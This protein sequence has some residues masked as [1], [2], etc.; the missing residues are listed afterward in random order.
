LLP[1]GAQEDDDCEAYLDNFLMAELGFDDLGEMFAE[2]EEMDE[3]E[4][5]ELLEDIGFFEAEE[6]CLSGERDNDDRDE[7]DEHVGDS[8]GAASTS[9]TALNP[10]VRRSHRPARR[11]K[12]PAD[13]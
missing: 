10:A 5:D 3:E 1:V 2:L 13:Y 6:A 12:A 11:R 8:S 9:N 7:H 4:L